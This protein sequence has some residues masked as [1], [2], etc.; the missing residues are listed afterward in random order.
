MIRASDGTQKLLSII[1]FR[2]AH[3]T[4]ACLR[5][6]EIQFLKDPTLPRRVVSLRDILD[7]DDRSRFCAPSKKNVSFAIDSNSNPVLTIKKCKRHQFDVITTLPL[8][9]NR[10]FG[11]ILAN[12]MAKIS[13]C[14]HIVGTPPRHHDRAD[15]LLINLPPPLAIRT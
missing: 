15:I 10:L 11:I 2:A 9:P 6:A 5:S 7:I 4:A 1:E 13:K 14:A 8:D 3:P 12:E